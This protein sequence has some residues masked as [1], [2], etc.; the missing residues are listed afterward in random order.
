MLLPQRFWLTPALTAVGRSMDF[1]AAGGSPATHAQ[2]R[3]LHGAYLGLEL[4][5]WAAGIGLAALLVLRKNKRLG[6][7]RQ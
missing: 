5:K 2:F 3:L 6:D 7:A 4:L 1:A